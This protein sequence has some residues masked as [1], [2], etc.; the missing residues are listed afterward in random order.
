MAETIIVTDPKEEILKAT[1]MSLK[2]K[3]YDIR[4]LN[5]KDKWRSDHYNPLKYIRKL[6][7]EAFLLDLDSDESRQDIVQELMD[8]GRNIA[9]DDVMNLINGGVVGLVGGVLFALGWQRDDAEG[10]SRG[11]MALMAGFMLIAIAQA[12]D[13]FGL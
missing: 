7:K 5:I 1:G 9:E 3:G 4:V 8:E 2:K 10:K 13:I 11:L 12:P 6:P